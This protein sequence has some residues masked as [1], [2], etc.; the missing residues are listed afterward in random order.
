M[1]L[2]SPPPR[3]ILVKSRE[4]N[5]A[6]FSKFDHF[7][8][9]N[10]LSVCKLRQLLGGSPPDQPPGPWTQLGDFHLPDPLSYS[11]P[12]MRIPDAGTGDSTTFLGHICPCICAYLPVQKLL[13]RN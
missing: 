9:Q 10:L 1:S 8:S 13:I 12:Q 4:V 2:G 3:N 5:C 11:L 7:C 6:R